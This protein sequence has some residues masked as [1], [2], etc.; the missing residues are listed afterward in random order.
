M[1]NYDYLHTSRNNIK[2]TTGIITTEE[3]WKDLTACATFT[4]TDPEENNT[5]TTTTYRIRRTRGSMP[6]SLAGRVFD[7]YEK[8]RQA[9]RKFLRSNLDAET[10]NEKREVV[11]AP[12]DGVNRNPP[13]ISLF[14]FRIE[15]AAN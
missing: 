7:S 1:K 2:S 3:L 4:H 11:M 9:V 12:W 15:K 6:R 10:Y 8:A 5:M 14:G 13:S